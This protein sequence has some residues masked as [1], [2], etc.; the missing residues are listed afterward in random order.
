MGALEEKKQRQSALEEKCKAKIQSIFPAKLIDHFESINE[1]SP[2]LL[3]TKIMFKERKSTDP[4]RKFDLPVINLILKDNGIDID[5]LI[6]ES[7]KKYLDILYKFINVIDKH[8]DNI[9][10]IPTYKADLFQRIFIS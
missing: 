8:F 7:E 5:K 6:E 2:R 1:K 4:Y 9:N 10:C 3:S